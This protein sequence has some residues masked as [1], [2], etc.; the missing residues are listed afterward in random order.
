MLALLLKFL[1]LKIY[2]EV[3]SCCCYNS[4]FPRV[5]FFFSCVWLWLFSLLWNVYFCI[6]WHFCYTV[7][8]MKA[9]FLFMIALPNQSENFLHCC[10]WTR[11]FSAFIYWCGAILLRMWFY[12]VEDALKWLTLMALTF[13]LFFL[14]LYLFHILNEPREPLPTFSHNKSKKK[15][16]SKKNK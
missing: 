4:C 9:D 10:I 16:M 7:K 11:H 6:L 12:L 15:K 13:S 5:M 1:G 8:I 14:S 2:T 3:A